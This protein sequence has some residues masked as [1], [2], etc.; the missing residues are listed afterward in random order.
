[1]AGPPRAEAGEG[2]ADGASERCRRRGRPAYPDPVSAE[3]ADFRTVMGQFATGV[4][5]VTTLDGDAPQGITVN[6]MASVSLEPPLVVIALDRRRFIN[7]AIEAGG[8]FAINILAEDQQWLSDCFAGANVNPGRDAFCGAAW[9][10]GANGMP[11][12]RGAMA[13]LECRVVDRLET[14]DHHLFVGEVEAAH[15][16]DEAAPPLLYHRRRYLRIERATTSVVAGKP[17]SPAG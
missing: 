8:R 15:L 7:P 9:D 1:M 10:P 16:H 4:T 12:L 2:A 14:G 13:A 3:T 17:E 11:L 5:I 6:A